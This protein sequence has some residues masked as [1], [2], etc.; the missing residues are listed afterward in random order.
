MADLQK[1]LNKFNSMGAVA[2]PLIPDDAQA[3]ANLKESTNN[4][5]SSHAQM[6][7]ESV[8]RLE[9]PELNLSQS[10]LYK[11]AGVDPKPL[12][13]QRPSP[14]NPA[15]NSIETPAQNTDVQEGDLV[16]TRR[17]FAGNLATAM[18][19][20]VDQTL[21]SNTRQKDPEKIKLVQQLYKMATGKDVEYNPDSDK[22]T[23]KS[24]VAPSNT[25]DFEKFYNQARDKAE[26]KLA[27]N[28]ETSTNKYK[29]LFKEY[30]N[31]K[32]GKNNE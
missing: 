29:S 12:P 30:L 10:D 13:T 26:R 24:S 28:E 16:V 21:D 25:F 31:A 4:V 11:L 19:D 27:S 2:Q 15:P 17:D 5:A 20:L 1:I 22:F 3:Q 18:R 6:I 23:V 14:A 7:N 9:L 8:S 32:E